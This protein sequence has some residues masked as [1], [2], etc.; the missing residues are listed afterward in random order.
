MRICW[1]IES[2]RDKGK[3]VVFTTHDPNVASALADSIVL[4]RKGRVAAIG[5][6]RNT[7]SAA[8]IKTTCG[9]DV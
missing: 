2:L 3:T 1:A 7:L 6:T 8:N 5:T 4:L 9:V